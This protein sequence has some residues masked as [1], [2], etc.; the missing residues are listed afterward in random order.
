MFTCLCLSMTFGNRLLGFF[1]H[2]FS[3]KGLQ[4][5]HTVFFLKKVCSWKQE[6]KRTPVSLMKRRLTF[7]S[8]SLKLKTLQ[9]IFHEDVKAKQCLIKFNKLLS[10]FICIYFKVMFL[11][12]PNH[13]LE[14]YV[15]S[16]QTQKSNLK[17]QK[18]IILALVCH[19]HRACERN[20]FLKILIVA[21]LMCLKY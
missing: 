7:G 4:L 17:R 1:N 9:F 6:K 14:H 21:I 11:F 16:F 8:F 12:Q 20:F 13:R 3:V 18:K 19:I 5:C 10:F 15:M 2:N